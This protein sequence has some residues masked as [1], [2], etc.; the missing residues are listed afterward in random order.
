M[1]CRYKK[2]SNRKYQNKGTET[3]I[4]NVFNIPESNKNA[5]TFYQQSLKSTFTAK[6]EIEITKKKQLS[7]E[8]RKI[9]VTF[10]KQ[11]LVNHELKASIYK[12]SGF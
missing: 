7:L 3:I 6:W 1:Q 4:C 11:S 12:N 10:P 5:K 9:F 8:F 2:H